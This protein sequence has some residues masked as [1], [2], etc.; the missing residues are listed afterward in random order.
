[1][2]LN[3]S[4]SFGHLAAVKPI[5]GQS[6]LAEMVDLLSNNV[7]FQLFMDIIYRAIQSNS[8]FH[9]PSYNLIHT[10]IRF[11][12]LASHNV[13]C[14]SRRSGRLNS[15]C[16]KLKFQNISYDPTSS[17]SPLAENLV[18]GR[19]IHSDPLSVIKLLF[20]VV[21]WPLP[22]FLMDFSANFN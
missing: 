19:S 1:L 20:F 8:V 7:I 10:S 15:P 6:K 16:E 18:N 13:W 22:T 2:D 14:H 21:S 17:V 3:E 4:A 11:E 12:T 5:N 9:P